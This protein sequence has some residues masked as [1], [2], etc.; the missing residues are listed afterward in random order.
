M[1]LD[2]SA[3]NAPVGDVT[4]A[5]LEVDSTL[6]RINGTTT[7][8]TAGLSEALVSSPAEAVGLL[9]GFCTLLYLFITAFRKACEACGK[10]VLAE[11]VP[12][13]VGTLRTMTTGVA[14]ETVPVM[15]AMMTAAATGLGPGLWRA[16]YGP[17]RPEELMA[18]ERTLLILAQE[19]NT[20][21][22]TD[23][24]ALRLV[25]DA[26]DAADGDSPR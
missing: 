16:S 11:T 22:G 1:V 12:L 15:A 9:D 14:P 4:A 7:G 26:L 17:W 2:M 13:V 24:A 5:I 3:S 10:D 25:M 20:A 21:H 6:K 19:I 8:S 18:L 23:D